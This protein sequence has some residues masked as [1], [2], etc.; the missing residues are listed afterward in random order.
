MTKYT[1]KITIIKIKNR[2]YKN[3]KIIGRVVIAILI[4]MSN[5]IKLKAKSL[6]TFLII[7]FYYIFYLTGF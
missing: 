3:L 7:F 1:K 4:I 5:F 2:D 6:Q